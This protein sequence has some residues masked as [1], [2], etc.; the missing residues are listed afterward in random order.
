[1]NNKDFWNDINSI[2]DE[3]FSSEGL[4]KLESYAEQ[5]I[6]G[7]LVYQRLSPAEQ[8]GCIAG[9]PTHVIASILA[10]AENWTNK[11]AGKGIGDFKREIER[12]KTQAAIIE[13]WARK[14]GCWIEDVDKTLPQ[15]L[16]ELIAEGGEAKVY[17]NGYLLVKTI[18][19]DY[20]I[21]P[22]LALDR[23]SL[24]NTLFPETSM[25]V[26]GFGKTSSQD[27]NIIV[28]QPFVE[29]SH[30]TN[31]AISEYIQRLG[32][33]LIN[34]RNWT[35]ATPEIY[36]SDLHDENVILSKEGNVFVVDCDVR[37]N[38]PELRCG[39]KRTLTTNVE[40]R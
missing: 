23:V 31:A 22:I 7:R 6:S 37:I 30:I 17:D 4:S 2:I 27:F 10:G 28:N 9:G 14:V 21:Q 24:H 34:P 29:G 1:M 20:F 32:F 3:G 38:I 13:Q 8:H 36:L 39:G 26:I 35:F 33:Q 40:F 18:G 25:E 11:D 12:G 15:T 5:F 19:L 16:G